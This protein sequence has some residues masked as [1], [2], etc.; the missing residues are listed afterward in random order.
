MAAKNM[1]QFKSIRH[2]VAQATSQALST[3]PKVLHRAASRTPK[4]KRQRAKGAAKPD[5]YQ[6]VLVGLLH[7][8]ADGA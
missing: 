4:E 7:E 3:Q 2:P 1:V 8:Y 6:R 5:R